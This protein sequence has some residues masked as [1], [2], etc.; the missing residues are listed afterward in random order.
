MREAKGSESE[1][2]SCDVGSRAWSNVLR[3]GGR[4]HM[5]VNVGYHQKLKKVKK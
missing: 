5:P 4:G 2:R 3:N 1:R